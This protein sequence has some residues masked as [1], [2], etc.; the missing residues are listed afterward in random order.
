MGLL[1][2]LPV[3]SLGR[4]PV[5]VVRLWLFSRVPAISPS[6]PSMAGVHRAWRKGH[7]H[8]SAPIATV[9]YCWAMVVVG[10]LVG[11]LILQKAIWLVYCDVQA[12]NASRPGVGCFCHGRGACKPSR[13]LWG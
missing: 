9:S 7:T 11:W 10:G 3:R 4:V 8:G 5:A 12:V 13:A 6:T 1:Y 2:S